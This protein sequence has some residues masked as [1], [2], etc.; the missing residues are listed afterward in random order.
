MIK[1]LNLSSCLITNKGAIAVAEMIRYNTRLEALYLKW[2]HIRAKGAVALFESIKNS[3]SL[4]I[5]EMAFNPIGEKLKPKPD[6]SPAPGKEDPNFLDNVGIPSL[7][8]L[9][10][11][12]VCGNLSA[13]FEKNKVL[14]HADFSHCGFSLYE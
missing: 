7:A 13:M 5:L 8:F 14:L 4:L 10:K 9:N 1:N 12:D 3:E 11:F 2:N 6:T